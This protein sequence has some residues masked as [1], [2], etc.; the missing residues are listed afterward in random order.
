MLPSEAERFGIEPSRAAAEHAKAK[1]IQIIDYSDL[2]RP[3][4]R[5][6]FDLV[7]AIDVVEHLSDLQEFRRQLTKALCPG[8]TV[9][10]LTGDA[11][12]ASARLL[13]RYWLYV[14]YAEHI[15]FFCRNSARV[16]LQNDFSVIEVTETN[17]H[18][19][20]VMDWLSLVRAWLFFPVK[21]ILRKVLP[22]HIGFYTA[23][24]LPGD[25]M[26]I[27]AIRNRTVMQ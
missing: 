25:H 16:W 27:R 10:I 24:S 20:D 15:N 5:N 2:A 18:R 13:G 26:L 21:W 23:L 17:H 14:N 12:S 7:T 8:G 6:S 1:G 11:K 3:E 22:M 9:I 4:L 19:L